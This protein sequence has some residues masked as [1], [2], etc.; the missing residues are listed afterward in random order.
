MTGSAYVAAH[1]AHLCCSLQTSKSYV[2]KVRSKTVNALD[3]QYDFGIRAIFPRH[4]DYV[5]LPHCPNSGQGSLV[6]RPLTGV[7]QISDN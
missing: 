4:S 5:S 1:F 3:G 6:I 7:F 2:D